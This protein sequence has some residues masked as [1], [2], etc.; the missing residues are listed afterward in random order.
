MI[1]RAPSPAPRR[2][3]LSRTC[4]TSCILL[5]PG[6]L[7]ATVCATCP[8]AR[9]LPFRFPT[10]GCLGLLPHTPRPHTDLYVWLCR[11]KLGV[12]RWSSIFLSV[13]K[14]VLPRGAGRGGRERA[15]GGGRAAF[16]DRAGQQGRSEARPAARRSARRGG[17]CRAR[18]AR[19]R[20]RCAGGRCAAGGGVRG[21]GGRDRCPLH[22]PVLRARESVS[23][24]AMWK[25]RASECRVLVR[26]SDLKQ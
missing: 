5:N 13:P 9:S 24:M 8:H 2:P 11:C 6:K 20:S 16:G 25:V 7:R 3:Q 18:G 10:A 22:S 21:A 26:A 4:R 17:R 1:G 12:P 14:E 15:C 19:M 23:H